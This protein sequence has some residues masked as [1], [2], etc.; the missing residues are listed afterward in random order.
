MPD[1][2]NGEELAKGVADFCITDEAVV[3]TNGKRIFELRFEDGEIKKKKLLNTDF[4]IK[5]S[6]ID[7][8]MSE[9]GKNKDLF[10][11]L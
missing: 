6:A 1:I 2:K 3:Y 5:I 10:Y 9:A 8:K 4:C 11:T 7:E